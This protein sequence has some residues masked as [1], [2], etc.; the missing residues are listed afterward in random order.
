MR[1]KYAV[2]WLKRSTDILTKNKFVEPLI[3][4]ENI[5]ISL[6]LKNSG[7]REKG[8]AL[9]LMI[10]LSRVKLLNVYL[11]STLDYI[12]MW[13][14]NLISSVYSEKKL[15]NISTEKSTCT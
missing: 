14:K 3:V 7:V 4:D 2:R 6:K 11:T 1:H 9:E 8:W 5:G 15:C 13:M 12:R 10:I